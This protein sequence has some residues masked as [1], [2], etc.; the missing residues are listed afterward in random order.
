MSGFIS[1]RG[2]DRR[3]KM[4]QAAEENGLIE[5]EAV[6]GKPYEKS[7]GV[8]IA[9]KKSLIFSSSCSSNSACI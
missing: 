9:M 5:E 1:D 2:G 6:T 7:F 8:S 3:K 4:N